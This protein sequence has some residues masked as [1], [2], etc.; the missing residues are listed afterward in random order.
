MD[1]ARARASGMGVGASRNDRATFG[2]RGRTVPRAWLADDGVGSAG[3]RGRPGRSPDGP[4][5]E[6][7]CA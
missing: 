5:R 3:D 2:T 1:E 6:H 4:T 7:G